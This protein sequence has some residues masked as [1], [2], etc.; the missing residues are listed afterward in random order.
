[1]AKPQL[2]KQV[3]ELGQYRL[4]F[5][6]D[7]SCQIELEGEALGI[8]SHDQLLDVK[9][10]LDMADAMMIHRISNKQPDMGPDNT[11]MSWSKLQDLAAIVKKSSKP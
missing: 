2:I 10:L 9:Q 5:W 6:G 4:T 3:Y 8:A 1:M 7:G 11:E